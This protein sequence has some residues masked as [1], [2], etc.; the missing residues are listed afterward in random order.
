MNDCA[1][2]RTALAEAAAACDWP[3]WNSLRLI[4]ADWL[5]ERGDPEFHL[6]RAKWECWKPEVRGVQV[7]GRIRGRSMIKVMK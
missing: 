7:E 2:F 5:Q 6:A 3:A 4:F 1:A